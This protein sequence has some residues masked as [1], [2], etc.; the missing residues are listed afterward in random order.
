MFKNFFKYIIYFFKED[1]CSNII[2]YMITVSRGER[3]WE[4]WLLALLVVVWQQWCCGD[5]SR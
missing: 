2:L 4:D 5:G 1:I 3:L